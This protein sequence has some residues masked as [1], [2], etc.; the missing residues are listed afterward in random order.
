MS[1]TI[2]GSGCIQIIGNTN[3]YTVD[4]NTLAVS[5]DTDLGTLFTKARSTNDW[6]VQINN[7]GDVAGN[8]QDVSKSF[9][10]VQHGY[11]Y[12]NSQGLVDLGTLGGETSL[13]VSI[14][15]NGDVIGTSDTSAGDFHVF[16]YSDSYG[17]MTDLSAAV[18][19]ASLTAPNGN[20]VG[21][22]AINDFGD[23][24]GEYGV[25]DAYILIRQP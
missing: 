7:R 17:G 12:S 5:N 21:V 8:S 9:Q 22:V 6:T 20:G 2:D 14:N 19:G 1:R 23:V 16:L 13:A 15:N 24:C 18:P 3:R 11:R 25:A 10:R 4:V